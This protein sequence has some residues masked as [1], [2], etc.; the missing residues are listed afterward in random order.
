MSSN[1]SHAP[2]YA[3]P[4][5]TTIVGSRVLIYP[6]IDSTNE[7]AL[8]LGGD[9]TVVVADEQTDGRG[10]RRRTWVSPAGSGLYVSVLLRPL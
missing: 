9:G 8:A 5:D 7:R 2:L 3:V 4:L 1:A 10:R 6:E